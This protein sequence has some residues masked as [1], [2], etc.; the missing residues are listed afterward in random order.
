M[1]FSEPILKVSNLHKRYDST[2]KITPINL[3]IR[4]LLTLKSK[5]LVNDNPLNLN[6]YALK[7]INFTIFPGQILGI[8]GRNGSGK[9]T[10]L[11]LL[12]GLISPT[13][14]KI[15]TDCSIASILELGIGFNNELSGEENSY[16]F[17]R[18][19]LL[20][21]EKALKNI[22]FIKAFSDLE[23]FFYKPVKYYSSGM[24]ARLAFACAISL[25][26]DLLIIDEILSVGDL[27]FQQKCFDYLNKEFLYNPARS[28]IYVGHNTETCMQLCSHGMVLDEGN[29]IYYGDIKK[30]VSEYYSLITRINNKINLNLNNSNS[31]YAIKSKNNEI[32]Y[33]LDDQWIDLFKS[34]FLNQNFNRI[35]E[36]KFAEIQFI[37]IKGMPFEGDL[38]G[39]ESLEFIIS[40]KC[41][42]K[43]A[44]SIGMGIWSIN[45]L[46]IAG[47]NTFIKK[48]NIKEVNAGEIRKY[49]LKTKLNLNEGTFLFNFGID[50]K[51]N[52]SIVHDDVFRYA[53]IIQVKHDNNFVGLTRSEIFIDEY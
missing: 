32:K 14:G 27:L 21:R 23:D 5:N 41:K 39:N 53:M 35:G 33:D 24:F 13:K 16:R 42:R 18:Y 7:N 44:P 26:A 20:S 48:I 52:S 12:S 9:S 6:H 17:G 19:N 30:A 1:K 36:R 38:I 8:L 51:I 40:V 43:F 47:S 2:F 25:E 29:C 31:N 50:Y 10:L 3:A 28:V 37:S 45:G 15:S 34:R 22:K 11:K 4:K 46:Q 49:I